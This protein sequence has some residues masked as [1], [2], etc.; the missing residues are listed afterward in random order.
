MV[1]EAIFVPLLTCGLGAQALPT[2]REVLSRVAK[3]YR[4]AN[5]YRVEAAI[6][7]RTLSANGQVAE[8]VPLAVPPPD[9]IDLAYQKPDMLRVARTNPR[10]ITVYPPGQP[11]P[12]RPIL[13]ARPDLRT[14]EEIARE[15]ENPPPLPPA[16]RQPD[17]KIWRSQRMRSVGFADYEAIEDG[18]GKTETLRRENL[19]IEG[20]SISCWVVEGS[21]TGGARRTFWVDAQRDLVLR[22]V[23][24]TPVKTVAGVK[25]LSGVE[26]EHTI[27]VQKL[28]W[29]VP[30]DD[31][32][33]SPATIAP[34][35][36]HTPNPDGIVPRTVVKNCADLRYPAEARTAHLGGSITVG[37]TID[38]RGHATGL[39][40]LTHLGLGLDELAMA[41]VSQARFQPAVR[42]GKPVSVP[43]KHTVHFNDVGDS[44][45]A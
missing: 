22:D 41:C 15:L 30:L 27:A 44:D 34:S 19:E 26:V 3:T 17:P 20:E 14:T 12:D 10:S 32:F 5:S 2:G 39:K 40:T 24:V 1:R 16:P 36:S 18:L 4:Q 42:D 38:E 11:A 33:A 35:A 45:W 7:Y 31:L 8:G 28:A 25:V 21:Y 23:R 9:V 6:T 43:W 37:F 29:N 13:D